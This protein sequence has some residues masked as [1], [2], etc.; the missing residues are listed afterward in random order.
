[1]IEIVRKPTHSS[2]LFILVT[3]IFLLS[4][5]IQHLAIGIASPQAMPCLF[6]Q[7]FSL[8]RSLVRINNTETAHHL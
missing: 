1:M 8:K 4:F 2:L 7:L 5:F 3:W 6:Y